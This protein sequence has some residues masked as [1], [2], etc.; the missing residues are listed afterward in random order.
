MPSY[1][2]DI[3]D[4]KMS[5]QQQSLMMEDQPRQAAALVGPW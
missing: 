1:A 4:G 2:R 3:F 5:A